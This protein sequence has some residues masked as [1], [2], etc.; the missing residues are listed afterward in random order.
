MRLGFFE[1]R[2]QLLLFLP[3]LLKHV[4]GGI[5]LILRLHQLL[6]DSVQVE[7]HVVDGLDLR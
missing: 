3:L 2:H 7:H 1:L 4:L 5:E 6:L